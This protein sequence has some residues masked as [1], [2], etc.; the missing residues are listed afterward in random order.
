MELQSSYETN[1]DQYNTL[2]RQLQR[3]KLNIQEQLPTFRILDDITAPG[4]QIQ[5]K[6]KL[7][8]LLSIVLGFFVAFSWVTIS[9]LLKKSTGNLFPEGKA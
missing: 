1:L 3:M 5:P 9:L 8:V 6:R 2:T 7:I 4:T